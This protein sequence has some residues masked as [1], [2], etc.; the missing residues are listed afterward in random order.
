MIIEFGVLFYEEVDGKDILSK[1]Y[2]QA[3]SCTEAV[4][5]I[6]KYFGADAICKLYVEPVS[7]DSLVIIQEKDYKYGDSF[8]LTNDPMVNKGF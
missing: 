2:I 8:E 7:C 6:E 1:G 5:K 4:T 3:D